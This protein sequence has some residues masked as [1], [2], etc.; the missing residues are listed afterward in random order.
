MWSDYVSNG[1]DSWGT[2]DTKA[3]EELFNFIEA[4][5]I[6]GVLLV[7]GDRHGARGF[8]IPRPSGFAFYEFEAGSLGGVPGPDAMAKDTTNQLF[9]YHGTDAIAFGEFSFDTT[10]S[11]PEVTFR[12]IHENGVVLYKITLKRSQLTSML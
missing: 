7:C 5:N 2:W 12:L 9:G 4:E 3:R 6:S 1:K 10:L 11:D 8:T